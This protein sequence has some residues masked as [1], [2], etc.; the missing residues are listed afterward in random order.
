MLEKDKPSPLRELQSAFDV[1]A[2]AEGSNPYELRG[3][4]GG[5]IAK[6]LKSIK[7][8]TPTVTPEEIARRAANYTNAWPSA[9]LSAAGIGHA[10]GEIRS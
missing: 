2:Q 3:S 7:E 1:L 8:S 9:A 4:A 10:L 5:R 6:A